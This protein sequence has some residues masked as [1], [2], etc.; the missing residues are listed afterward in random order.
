MSSSAPTSGL[1][2][3]ASEEPVTGA[4]MRQGFL[5]GRHLQFGI[6]RLGFRRPGRRR[7]S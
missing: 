6:G 3:R 4:E 5:L 2:A 1:V 7:V